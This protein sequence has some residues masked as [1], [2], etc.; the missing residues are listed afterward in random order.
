MAIHHKICHTLGGTYNLPHAQAHAITLAYSVHYN[1][2]AD[3]EAMDRLVEAL[4][5]SNREEVGL[6]IY[7]LNQSLGI[8]LAL[9]DIG[10]PEEGPAEVAQIICDSLYY[11][12]RD[13]DY[14]ELKDLLNKAYQGLSPA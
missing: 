13:Y 6:E 3:V 5:V 12:P 4:G 7:R 11:N 14:E 2:N 1:R 9:K 8:P 10:L